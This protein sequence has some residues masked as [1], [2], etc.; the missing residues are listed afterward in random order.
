MGHFLFVH[1]EIPK[2]QKRAQF[3]WGH[4]TESGAREGQGGHWL[5]RTHLLAICVQQDHIPHV[6]SCDHHSAVGRHI[7]AAKP[8]AKGKDCHETL[9]A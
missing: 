1:S 2:L 8:D 6:V 3:R 9:G 5:Q 7:Q 4:R